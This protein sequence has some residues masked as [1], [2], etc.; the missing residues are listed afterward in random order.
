MEVELPR[1]IFTLATTIPIRKAPVSRSTRP[2]VNKPTLRYNPA[3]R[4]RGQRDRLTT[5]N[6]FLVL[7]N[8]P[9]Y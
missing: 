3:E 6:P 1:P 9:N 5:L 2:N 4:A 8:R 7:P